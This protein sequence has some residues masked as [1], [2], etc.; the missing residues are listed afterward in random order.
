[1][2]DTRVSIRFAR[3]TCSI[4]FFMSLIL[5]TQCTRSRFIPDGYMIIAARISAIVKYTQEHPEGR[6]IYQL[7]AP[8]DYPD[9]DY[10]ITSVAYDPERKLIAIA[11]EKKE[12]QR[13]TA[14]I[15]LLDEKTLSFVKE[16]ITKKDRIYGMSI[17]KEGRIAIA[18]GDMYLD[19]P[20][21]LCYLS[22]SD[23]IVHTI[24]KGAHFFTPAWSKDSKRV[25][26]GFSPRS[27]QSSSDRIGYVELATP[28]D[29][30]QIADGRSVS[31]SASGKVAYLTNE[32][33]IFMMRDMDNVSASVE[34]LRHV[35]PKFTDSIYF[36][37]GTEDIVIKH[38]KVTGLFS[39]LIVLQPPYKKEK[40]M[41]PYMGM[42][43][44]DAA[45]IKTESSP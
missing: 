29:I 37:Q 22:L 24:A 34:L 2:F 25:Y 17:D 39:D 44:F 15:K 41:L 20:G 19:H 18:T 26:F 8:G 45:Y 33:D 31:V 3:L 28:Y 42:Q 27:K 4:I 38:W 11:M 10:T 35:D 43:D 23:G 9:S 40:L 5:L 6:I 12:P 13:G 7:Y 14:I 21:E 32:G 30:K 16:I 36:V 1:M